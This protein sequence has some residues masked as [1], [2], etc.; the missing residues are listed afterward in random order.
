MRYACQIWAQKNNL[1]RILRL[2]KQ[3]LRL[4]TFSKLNA[5]S[6][7]L[8]LNLRVLKLPD[9]VKLL[10]ICLISCILNKT[11]PTALID[12]YNLTM[13]PDSHNTRGNSLG[14]LTRPACRT[15][16]YG[17]NSIVY[18]SL[19][20]WNELRLLY[21]EL[22]LSNISTSELTTQYKSIIFSDY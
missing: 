6:S 5:S 7:P 8:F 9:L 12:I 20:Q 19:V 17:I 10:N 1:S 4:I 11:A 3:C 22:D 13:Y 18:Q 15:F 2:Q 14:L 21:P 16:Q